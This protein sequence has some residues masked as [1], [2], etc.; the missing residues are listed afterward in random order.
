MDKHVFDQ[1]QLSPVF[2]FQPEY[3]ETNNNSYHIGWGGEAAYTE[4][5]N[6]SKQKPMAN[7]TSFLKP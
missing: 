7:H 4:P 5:I 1:D 6:S 2:Y 3:E